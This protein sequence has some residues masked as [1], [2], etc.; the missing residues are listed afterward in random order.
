MSKL[1]IGDNAY[2]CKVSNGELEFI[3]KH[4]DITH[5]GIYPCY[6]KLPYKLDGNTSSDQPPFSDRPYEKIVYILTL[7]PLPDRTQVEM[8]DILKANLGSDLVEASIF[9]PDIRLSLAP[10]NIGAS[11]TEI[12]IIDDVRVISVLEKVSPTGTS[13]N[14]Q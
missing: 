8:L 10:G 2:L 11:I 12:S 6:A 14:R 1:R 3:K 4:P 7:H 13:T 5:L 9:G